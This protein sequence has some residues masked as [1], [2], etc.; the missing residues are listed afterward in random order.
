[1]VLLVTLTSTAEN[2]EV[3]QGAP[4]IPYVVPSESVPLCVTKISKAVVAVEVY[5]V[6]TYLAVLNK[7]LSKVLRV[8]APETKD[9]VNTL[10][11][12]NT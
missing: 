6:T 8:L 9:F 7:V 2:K 12:E 11:F 10:V 1:M 4:T 5:N 3:P